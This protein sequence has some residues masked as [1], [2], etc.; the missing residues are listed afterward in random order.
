MSKMGSRSRTH[1]PV[2]SRQNSMSMEDMHPVEV[3]KHTHIVMSRQDEITISDSHPSLVWIIYMSMEDMH[4]VEVSKHHILSCQDKKEFLYQ[5]QTTVMSRQN[6][7]HKY[8]L[9]KEFIY[10]DSH[11]IKYFLHIICMSWPNAISMDDLSPVEP[12]THIKS[13]LEIAFC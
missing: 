5:T 6:S 10:H 7:A 9:L 1:T 4:P 11:P 8:C 2:M 13:F 3:S 12:K